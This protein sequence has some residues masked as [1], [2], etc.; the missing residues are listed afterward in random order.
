MN[1][2]PIPPAN[3]YNGAMGKQTLLSIFF[4]LVMLLVVACGT[5]PP[6]REVVPIPTLAELPTNAPTAT[7]S[8]TPVP[9]ETVTETLTET[10]TLTSTPAPTTTDAPS[11][12]PSITITDTPAPTATQPPPPTDPAADSLSALIEIALRTTLLPTEVYATFQPAPTLVVAGGTPFGGV[13][14]ATA[15]ACES[16]PSGAFGT[17]YSESSD[18]AAQLGC[19]LTSPPTTLAVTGA[20]QRFENGA[21]L[22]LVGPPDAIF[23]LFPDGR[24]QRFDDTYDEATDPES[25][26][27]TPPE[28]LLGP[29]RGFGKVWRENAE[30][31]AALGWALNAEQGAAA[32]VMWFDNGRMVYLP[33]WDETVALVLDPD[34]LGG[35]YQ[36]FPG[37]AS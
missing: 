22:F 14:A 32:T 27:E 2:F 23:V 7:V 30:V 26:G 19:P 1:P 18:L 11:L 4:I 29:I 13:V 34:G 10:V 25:G 8:E 9:T 35:T 24:F 15:T 37:G 3:C 6:D 17:F 21:M 33:Q 5:Q 16:I 36:T 12:T 28:G 31:R 20:T